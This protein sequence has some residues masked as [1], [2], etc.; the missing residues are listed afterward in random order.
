VRVDGIGYVFTGKIGL[1][2]LCIGGIDLDDLRK[3][4]EGEVDDGSM[5][6][7]K[8]RAGRI[9]QEARALG[10]YLEVSPSRGGLHILGRMRPLAHGVRRDS[11]EFYTSQ[12]YFTITTKGADGDLTDISDLM[13]PLI[14]EIT[15]DRAS[16]SQTYG[17]PRP[18]ARL[19]PISFEDLPT[20]IRL[21]VYS[22]LTGGREE[23]RAA[24]E[25]LWAGE[26][27]HHKDDHSAADLSFIAQIMRRGLS[28]D[29]A[30]QALRA[31]G[32]MRPKWDEKRGSTT[33]GERT[34]AVAW[35]GRS[36]PGLG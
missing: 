8:Q 16:G 4:R 31:S 18:F 7:R 12:R 32:L 1:D 26:L 2:G 33:Y 6:R 10:A 5:I 35:M 24:R 13:E 17:S 36:R 19:G 25:Q 14:R 3:R 22:W 11:V 15:R 29:E 21:T 23:N 27:R 9:V 30:D 28:V 34:I 20:K